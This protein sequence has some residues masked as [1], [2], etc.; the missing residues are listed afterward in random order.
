M[1]LFVGTSGYSYKEWKG[2]FYPE[3]LPADQMLS[4]YAQHFNTVEINN[5][6]YRMPSAG[7]LA[8]WTEQV[9]A[10][11]A[12]VLKAPQRITHHL[13][14]RLTEDN[15]VGYF[16]DTAGVLGSRLGPLLF[17]LPPTLK[18]DVPRL[19]SFLA[20]LPPTRSAAFEFRHASWY[21][22][23]VYELLA[24]A[25]ATLCAADTDEEPPAALRATAE[26]GYLR[27]RRVEYSDAELTEWLKKIRSQ[28][29]KHAYVFFKHEDEARGPRFARRFLELT[30]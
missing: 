15:A 2:S 3:K 30:G 10:D 19:R 21:D 5:T 13:Q 11:F 6:F 14:L 20:A 17:Q 23:E 22:D 1:K 26:W 27:L 25:K 29:W 9:P 4:F 24:T 16:A 28:P 18:K 7:L 8:Q 12:F